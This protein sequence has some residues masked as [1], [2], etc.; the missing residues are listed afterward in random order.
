MTQLQTR[1]QTQLDQCLAV[2]A[3]DPER[4]DADASPPRLEP[5]PPERNEMIAVAAYFLA[6]RRAFAPGGAEAD[7]LLAEQQIDR[8]LA[9]ARAAGLDRAALARIGLRNALRLWGE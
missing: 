6:E 2:P 1:L 5:S 9:G 8:L 4:D 7:W 3:L